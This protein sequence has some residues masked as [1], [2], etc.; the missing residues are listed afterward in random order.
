MAERPAACYIKEMVPFDYRT[1]EGRRRRF[2]PIPVRMLVPNVITLLAIC[3]GLA[4]VYVAYQV[5]I[6]LTWWLVGSLPAYSLA[7]DWR[8][9]N[10]E[11]LWQDQKRVGMKNPKPPPRCRWT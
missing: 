3:A 5:P 1:P 6:L 11:N 10:V 8:A 9:E 4:S 2:R 7:P